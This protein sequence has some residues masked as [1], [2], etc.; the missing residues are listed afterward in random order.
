MSAVNADLTHLGGN[1]HMLIFC[2]HTRVCMHTYM[3]MYIPTY[4]PT[5]LPRMHA[6]TRSFQFISHDCVEPIYVTPRFW[7]QL[8][9]LSCS[10]LGCANFLSLSTGHQKDAGR[11]HRGSQVLHRGVLLSAETNPQHETQ[12]H[13]DIGNLRGIPSIT[14]TAPRSILLSCTGQVARKQK[15]M[16]SRP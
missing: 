13:P 15:A 4:L 7:F 2:M 8:Q 1:R 9:S 3:R 5:S 14:C 16:G 10:S 12:W 6:Y 11:N